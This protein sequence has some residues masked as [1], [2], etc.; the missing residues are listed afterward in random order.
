MKAKLLIATAIS[1]VLFSGVASADTFKDQG[2]GKVTF[3]GSII[4]A[5]CSIDTKSVNQIVSLGQVANKVLDNGGKS[6]PKA[7]HINLKDCELDTQ[8][9]VEVTFT[10]ATDANNA[11]M[12]G[13][14]GSASGAGIMLTDGSGTP[15]T[16][17]QATAGQTLQD[18]NNTLA[19]SAYLQ[20]DNA[21]GTVVPGAFT[22]VTNFTLKYQ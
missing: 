19:F 2:H 21:S 10:G 20:G 13:I 7:F 16:L 8:K 12:L 17:G 14:T 18:G 1:A 15:I 3:V 9:T 11:A 4:D 22:S 5:P 6:E